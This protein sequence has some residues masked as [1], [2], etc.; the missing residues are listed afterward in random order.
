MV[1]YWHDAAGRTLYPLEV[2]IMILLMAWHD[3]IQFAQQ[4]SI[5]VL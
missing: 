3:C 4:E 1:A 2:V 5:I